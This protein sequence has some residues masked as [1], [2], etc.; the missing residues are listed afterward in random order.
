MRWSVDAGAD[1]RDV[2]AARTSDTPADT[3]RPT[4]TATTTV[5]RQRR[6]RNWLRALGLRST[7][8]KFVSGPRIAGR[9]AAPVLKMIGT[10]ANCT[11]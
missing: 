3:V 8:K 9:T 10:T 6:L 7:E 4:A 1:A 11:G 5:M 2:E